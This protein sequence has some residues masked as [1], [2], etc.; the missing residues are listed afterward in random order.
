M[1]TKA[2]VAT[3]LMA[4]ASAD[5]RFAWLYPPKAP[6]PNE[7]GHWIVING[8]AWPD[9]TK[10][11]VTTA[12]LSGGEPDGLKAS[13]TKKEKAELKTGVF[14]SAWPASAPCSPDSETLRRSRNSGQ[15]P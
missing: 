10:S 12:S 13:P 5:A 6:S 11:E 3:L 14:H 9:S 1:K 4:A 15:K 2:I 8:D 7:I